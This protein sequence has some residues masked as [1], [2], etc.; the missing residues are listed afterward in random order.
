VG[1]HKLDNY[2]GSRGERVQF[3]IPTLLPIEDVPD[4]IRRR[5][6]I[7]TDRATRAATQRLINLRTSTQINVAAEDNSDDF[8]KEEPAVFTEAPK[9]ISVDK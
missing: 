2:H 6:W 7:E 9:K 1:S 3:T 5:V 8:S 4:A